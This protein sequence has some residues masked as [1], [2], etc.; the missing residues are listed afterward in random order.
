[1]IIFLFS[2]DCY[3]IRNKIKSL[4][5]SSYMALGL[6]LGLMLEL[7]LGYGYGYG[8]ILKANEFWL[9]R[10]FNLYKSGRSKNS[11]I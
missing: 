8:K 7:C 1:M 4:H 9:A 11:K 10:Y 6:G 2:F 5:S 3:I